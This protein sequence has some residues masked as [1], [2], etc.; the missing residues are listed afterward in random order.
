MSATNVPE[1]GLLR[2]E[3]KAAGLFEHHEARGWL[4]IAFL[5]TVVGLCMAGI[6]VW[7]F[8]ASLVLIPIA[9]VFGT[10]LAMT[11]HEGSH[12][13]FSSSK[14]RNNIVNYLAFP[15]FSGL[16][17]LYWRDKHDRFHHGH[18]NVEGLDPDIKPWPFASSLGDH[19]KSPAGPKWWQRN[20][21]SWAF[22][23]MSSL[24]AL[25][26]R[27]SSLIHLKN[28]P[29][30]R[31][32]DRTWVVDVVCVSMHYV[33]WLVIPSLIWGPLAAFYVYCAT[34]ALV[35]TFLTLIFL[36][37]HAGMPIMHTQNH[38]WVHQIETTRNLEMP[39]LVSFFFIGLDRQVEH[40]LFPKIPHRNLPEATRITR[41]F[42]AKHGI[43]YHSEPY[44]MALADSARFM[45]SAWRTPSMDPMEVRLGLV[46]SAPMVLPEQAGII[47][48]LS[49]SF[50]RPDSM[51]T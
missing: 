50:V 51:T 12:K 30:Q 46:G 33:A 49:E 19:E 21:Q 32:I 29:S 20:M 4:K 1:L 18:P 11:G 28:Y 39:K 10:A 9:A 31:G 16:S 26:M 45:R 36:P 2:A 3:L 7:G 34:W 48:S 42:C 27:R 5:L 17:T 25:G 44:L 14:A 41:E 35:G 37:A 6:A 38:D 47:G 24:L 43:P 40:H 13:S 15:L 22:W 23:P 8:L